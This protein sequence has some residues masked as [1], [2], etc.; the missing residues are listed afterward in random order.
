MKTI[1]KFFTKRHL[2]ANALTM[3]ILLGG[4]YSLSR[5]NREEFPNTDT[6]IIMVRATYK[7]AAAE[8][9]ELQVTNEIE[10]ALNDIVGVKCL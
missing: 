3:M 4:F 10:D 7:G 6:G 8:D 5:I 9:V 1:F 2:L